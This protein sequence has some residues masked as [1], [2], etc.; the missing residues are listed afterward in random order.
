MLEAIILSVI[1]LVGCVF[2]QEDAATSDHDAARASRFADQL[3][4]QLEVRSSIRQQA[5]TLEQLDASLESRLR[6]AWIQAWHAEMLN[7]STP[8]LQAN[9]MFASMRPRNLNIDNAEGGSMLWYSLQDNTQLKILLA[10]K[11]YE[12]AME[13]Q[14]NANT[15]ANHRAAILEIADATEDNFQEFRR[16]VDWLGRRSEKEHAKALSLA[17]D[18][19]PKDRLNP[20]MGLIESAALRSLGDFG[21]CLRRLDELDDYSDRMLVM[22]LVFR[23]QIE[24]LNDNEASVQELAKEAYMLGKEYQ[25]LEP[26]LVRGWI[27]ISDAQWNVAHDCAN[28]ILLVDPD[29]V[30]GAVLKA[31]ATV[32]GKKSQAKEAATILRAAKVHTDRDDWYFFEASAYVYAAQTRWKD[33]SEAINEALKRSPSHCSSFLEAMKTELDKKQ[34]PVIDWK[35]RFKETWTLQTH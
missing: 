14:S 18:R 32:L 26:L 15:L 16:R 4:L 13:A 25:I 31:W 22:H 29:S 17:S 33:A 23:L 10:S 21:A 9:P 5:V 24:F 2:T 6:V 19:K 7:R 28:A 1:T 35:K 34:L 11:A 12:Q 20:G 8:M 30:E 3:K 27:A